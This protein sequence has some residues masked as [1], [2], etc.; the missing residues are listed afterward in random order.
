M[1]V[2][3]KKDR[4]TERAAYEYLSEYRRAGV[5][6]RQKEEELLNLRL[7]AE[8][9]GESA[10]GGG[11]R[12]GAGAAGDALGNLVAKIIEAEELLLLERERLLVLRAKVVADIQALKNPKCS[13]LL[14]RRYIEGKSFGRIAGE[15]HYSSDYVRG[16]LHPAALLALGKNLLSK[17]KDNTR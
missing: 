12:V 6:L 7:Q 14:Y 5:L 17:V 1:V 15:M 3:S 11:E 9:R 10:D 16:R 8:Y 4:A 13:D 2:R